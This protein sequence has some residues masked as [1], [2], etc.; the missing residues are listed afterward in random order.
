MIR[1]DPNINF[2]WGGGSPDPAIDPDT[3]SARWEGSIVPRYSETYTFYAGSDD[4]VRL[5]VNGQLVVDNWYD[6]APA[7]GAGTINLVAGQSYALRMEYYENGGGAMA[8]LAWSSPSQPKEIVPRSQLFVPSNSGEYRTAGTNQYTMTNGQVV[9]YDN[10]FNLTSYN[11][12]S[13]TFDAANHLISARKGTNSG[14][15]VYDGLGRCLKRT[16]NGVETIYIYDGWKA[17]H[18]VD[19]ND[20]VRAWN[21]YGAGQDEILWH[22][23]SGIGDLRYHHD[24]HGNVTALL[25]ASGNGLEKYTYDAFGKPTITDWSGNV[26]ATSAYNSRFMFQGRDYLSEFGIYDYRNR[27]YQPELG[28]FL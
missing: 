4:G 6:R 23:P 17:I 16:I 14:S 7:E 18:E 8:T 5:W 25:D 9:T 19:Q 27:F 28:R 12:A 21:I 1:V 13:F 26:R 20:G 10:N 11:G 22:N 15:F 24:M 2:D 3:F